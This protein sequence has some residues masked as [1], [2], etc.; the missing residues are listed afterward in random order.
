MYFVKSAITHKEFHRTCIETVNK[1]LLG[2]DDVRSMFTGTRI[3]LPEPHETGFKFLP[4]NR[5]LIGCVR[6]TVYI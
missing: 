6:P 5:L 1:A 3:R 2:I 4:V